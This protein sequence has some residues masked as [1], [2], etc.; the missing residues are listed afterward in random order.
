MI[1]SV[2]LALNPHPPDAVSVSLVS[3]LIVSISAHLVIIPADVANAQPITHH[4]VL[5]ASVDS[6]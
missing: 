6:S 1:H 5:S 4:L 3:T 2:T